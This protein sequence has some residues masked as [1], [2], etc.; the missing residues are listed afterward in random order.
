MGV[1]HG[2]C[3]EAGNEK[4]NARPSVAGD[5]GG[6]CRTD[7]DEHLRVFSIN[8]VALWGSRLECP[9]GEEASGEEGNCR[10]GGHR[11]RT[12]KFAEF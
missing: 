9:E 2:H 6:N 10:T 5:G 12:G 1:Q 3:S 8:C 11:L 7:H 4:S